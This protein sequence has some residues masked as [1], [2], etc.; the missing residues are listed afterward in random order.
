M[1]ITLVTGSSISGISSILRV[2]VAHS[3]VPVTKATIRKVSHRLFRAILVS[4]LIA[5]GLL[6]SNS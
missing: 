4:Q 1:A 5:I 6:I 2:T 3:E